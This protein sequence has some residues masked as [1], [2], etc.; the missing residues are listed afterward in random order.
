[1][2]IDKQA[3]VIAGFTSSHIITIALGVVVDAVFAF[4]L[5]VFFKSFVWAFVFFMFFATSIIAAVKLSQNLP[6]GYF[7]NFLENRKLPKFY[8]P[9][10]NNEPDQY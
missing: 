4:I 2:N 3:E 6:D 1:M 9:G 7:M 5:Y 10:E 8:M